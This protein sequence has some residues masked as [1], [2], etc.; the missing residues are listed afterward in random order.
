M[1]D[2]VRYAF[3]S[4]GFNATQNKKRK[5]NLS[6]PIDPITA[7]LAVTGPIALGL[8]YG[9]YKLGKTIYDRLKKKQ[10][11]VETP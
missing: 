10:E 1:R 7:Y 6:L 4:H 5:E 3:S 11:V 2:C 8:M 9:E